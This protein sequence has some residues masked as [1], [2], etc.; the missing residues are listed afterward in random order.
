MRNLSFFL[1]LAMA[2][3]SLVL[4]V[5]HSDSRVTFRLRV[6]NANEVRI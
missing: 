1:M 6:P 5:T 3:Q 2:R 4:P